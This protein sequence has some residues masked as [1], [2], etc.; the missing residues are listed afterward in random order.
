MF[1]TLKYRRQVAV[2]AALAMVAS[3]L[4]AAPAVAADPMPDFPAAFDACVGD[5]A[6]SAGFEDVPAGHANAGDID[7]IAYYGITRGTSP[8][9]YSPSMSVTRE[10]MALFLTRLAG[11]VGIE[12]TSTPAGAGFTDIGELSAESQTAINQ[13]ADLGIT[14]GTSA[15]T[16]SPADS[17]TRGQMGLFIA[18]LMNL[19]D[20][21]SDGN[22]TNGDWS[23]T[24]SDVV[25]NDRGLTIGSPYTDLGSAS[26]FAYDAITQLYELGVVSGISD[27]AYGPSALITRAAMAEFMAA[28]LDHSNARPAGLTIQA[29][30]TSGYG[31]VSA[32]VMVSH[33]DDMYMPV[34]DQAVDVFSSEAKGGGLDERGKCVTTSVSGDCRWNS[35]DEL[36]NNAGNIPYPGLSVAD[37]GTAVFYA[38]IGAKDGDQFDRDEVD[39]TSVSIT[40]MNDEGSVTVDD[41]VND[42][43]GTT[44][45]AAAT[46]M[47]VH[48]GATSSVTITLQ[49]KSGTV[50]AG[51]NVA[52]SG[53]KFTVDTN[54]GGKRTD[55]AAVVETDENGKATY[56]VTGPTD[57]K[58]DNA[59]QRLDAITFNYKGTDTTRTNDD[60]TDFDN[61]SATGLQTS[62]TVRIAWIETARAA[63]TAVGQADPYVVTGTSGRGTVSATA[64]FYDQYG[65]SIR[66]RSG[67]Q[68][69]IT[70]GGTAVTVNVNHRGV[71]RTSRAL[72]TLSP[73]TEVVV[74]YNADPTETPNVDL[75]AVTSPSGST[76]EVVGDAGNSDT[77]S[78]AVHTFF[79]KEN[80]F[81][82]ESSSPARADLLYSYDSDDTF[83]SGAAGS[84]RTVITMERFEE[85]LAQPPPGT[86]NGAAVDVSSYSAGG[87]SIF[88]VTLK[89]DG[90]AP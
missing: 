90:N 34:A 23:Y 37:G 8:T 67:Q 89:A 80:K 29:S 76:V 52:R 56:T 53:V 10:H 15:T 78:K 86:D 39:Y 13:L 47:N 84:A 63:A 16:Y 68:A 64:T 1:T 65:D 30:R 5:A 62:A 51:S 57:D 55:E 9:T 28:V 83:L 75:S 14:R 46:Y 73:G 61:D 82:T 69:E 42:R 19:M 72:I 88:V 38:W 54:L 25:D 17:V 66:T 2:L 22:D 6:E 21:L 45:D 36:T 79:A 74:S 27:T 50:G 20:P 77:G 31:T 26:K 33:R 87:V 49:L 7:C 32:T 71:A 11:L 58:K 4:V 85:L 59:Q 44:T 41:G 43:A 24:P 12:V 81:T 70:I 35:N 40:S 60:V 18:R 48:L 3:V